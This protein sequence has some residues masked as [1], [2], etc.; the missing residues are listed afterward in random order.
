[1][2]ISTMHRISREKFVKLLEGNYRMSVN[3]ARA[4]ANFAN[5]LIKRD[6]A[7]SFDENEDIIGPREW[8]RS[9]ADMYRRIGYKT[10]RSPRGMKYTPAEIFRDF[11]E[12][13]YIE[14]YLVDDN[15]EN[16]TAEQ[17]LAKYGVGYLV[18]VA[19]A[20]AERYDVDGWEYHVE[21]VNDILDGYPEELT[22][23]DELRLAKDLAKRGYLH[24][25]A[26]I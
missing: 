9:Y 25:S 20:N 15:G 23:N 1:M 19:Y 16:I 14:I 17:A 7:M 24:I 4:V 12:V 2:N 21:E 22:S 6:T 10:M 3:D 8:I 11:G 26:E 13:G 18:D 5:A